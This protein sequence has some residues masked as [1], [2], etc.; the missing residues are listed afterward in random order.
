MKQIIKRAS[1]HHHHQP[2]RASL[3]PNTEDDDQ[4]GGERKRVD[5]SASAVMNGR[6]HRRRCHCLQSVWKLMDWLK[7]IGWLVTAGQPEK[8][9]KVH[10]MQCDSNQ[11]STREAN[12]LQLDD[13]NWT[14]LKRFKVEEEEVKELK[15]LTWNDRG[16]RENLREL[17]LTIKWALLCSCSASKHN[18]SA[19]R[20]LVE[21]TGESCRFLNACPRRWRHRWC[22]LVDV[23]SFSIFQAV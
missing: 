19:T 12:R 17:N 3:G 13:C 7:V 20:K 14:Y 2:E 11:Q 22:C 10:P 1:H 5:A 6:R 4:L 9:W 18:T 23:L 8:K 16:E 15:E 21:R